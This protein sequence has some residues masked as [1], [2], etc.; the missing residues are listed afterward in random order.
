M[1]FEDERRKRRNESQQFTHRSAKTDME[2]TYASEPVNCVERR[3]A[4]KD[5]NAKR[6]RESKTAQ[7]IDGGG[8]SGLTRA[9]SEAG[10][11]SECARRSAEAWKSISKDVSL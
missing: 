9:R 2:R 7:L 11:H 6:E 5:P 4:Q 10:Q 8:R 1:W 3:Q